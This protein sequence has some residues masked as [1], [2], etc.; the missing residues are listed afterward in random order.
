MRVACEQRRSTDRNERLRGR[1]DGASRQ[2][3]A[4]RLKKVFTFDIDRAKRDIGNRP[5]RSS[6]TQRD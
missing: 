1:V 5:R 6:E 4:G 3:R 2:R